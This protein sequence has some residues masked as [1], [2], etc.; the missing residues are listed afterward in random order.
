ML[1][2]PRHLRNE[3]G[4]ATIEI[5]PILIV[6]AILIN[7][8]LGFFGVIQTGILNSI[9]ARNY[10]FETFRNRTNLMYF[11]DARPGDGGSSFKKY[12]SR[13]HGIASENRPTSGS[14]DSWATLRP[15]GFGMSPDSSSGADVHEPGGGDQRGI[16]GIQEG[17]RND[18]IL[19]APVWLRPMYGICLNA[20]CSQ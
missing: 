20:K 5:I 7:F 14:V 2:T 9:A 10:A 8:A 17:Q 12:N 13:V 15:I 18:S 4:M 3:K 6:I 16:F 11:H 1:K 19:S